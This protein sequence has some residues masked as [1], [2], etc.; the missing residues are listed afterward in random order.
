MRGYF[1]KFFR[2]TERGSDL[3]LAYTYVI[4]IDSLTHSL[5][6]DALE[7]WLDEYIEEVAGEVCD[8]VMWTYVRSIICV[9]MNW[10]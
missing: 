8:R 4:G 6:M 2:I 5:Y 9:C 10:W 1:A 7:E 3:G